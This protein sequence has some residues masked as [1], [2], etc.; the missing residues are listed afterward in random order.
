[1]GEMMSPAET[2]DSTVDEDTMTGL[3]CILERKHFCAC[4]GK[5]IADVRLEF[6]MGSGREERMLKEESARGG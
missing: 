5:H 6:A 1:M 4:T 3:I 2:I